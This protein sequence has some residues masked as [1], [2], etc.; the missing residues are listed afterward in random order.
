MNEVRNV[1]GGFNVM[2]ERLLLGRIM[3]VPLTTVI[4]RFWWRCSRRM[5][6][7]LATRVTW[8]TQKKMLSNYKQTELRGKWSL[9]FNRCGQGVTIPNPIFENET[10]V[11]NRNINEPHWYLKRGLVLILKTINHPRD[12]KNQ[13]IW[14]VVVL[15]RFFT[16]NIL[17]EFIT[18]IQPIFPYV[19]QYFDLSFWKY[20]LEFQC[21]L[22]N[23]NFWL[24][25]G[26][27]T[28]L[29]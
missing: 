13:G 19:E 7:K 24:Y 18:A 29:L 16:Q 5:Y 10:L 17:F 1:C 8:Y 14:L 22:E 20:S 9:Y 25:C 2:V 21:F 15:P 3:N 28:K 6:W 23:N 11:H 27:I 26:A 4:E 12:G